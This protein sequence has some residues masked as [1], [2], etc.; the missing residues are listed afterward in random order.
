MHVVSLREPREI[1]QLM[2]QICVDKYGID[3]MLPKAI[4]R[5]VKL[6]N[7]SNITANILKQEMLSLGAD[8]AIARGSLTGKAKK[9]DCLLMGNISQFSR[10]SE[11]LKLQPFGLSGLS[12][13]LKNVL[14]DYQKEDYILN[15]GGIKFNLWK[16]TLVMA[17][18][19]LTPDSFSAD[20]L[21]GL[22]VSRIVRIIEEKKNQGVD[23]IDIGGESSRPGAKPVSVKEELRRV[24]PVV[25][26]VFKNIKIPISVDTSKPQVAKA[27]LENGACLINDITGLK[28]NK[29]AKIILEAKAGVIIMHMKGSP[30]TMQ[31]NPQYKCVTDEIIRYLGQRI[32]SAQ[33]VGI[34]KEKIIVDP[35]IGF[36]KTLEHNLEILRKLSEFRS[37]GVPIMV[38]VSRKSFIGKLTNSSAQERIPGS[39][40]AGVLAVI[41]GAHIVRVHDVRE[42]V[43][44]MRVIDAVVKA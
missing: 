19:N 21:F 11:K 39:I 33:S 15:L 14:S 24:I 16:R 41:N 28:D 27:A 31:K 32:E 4:T 2:R 37:L 38:G 36:G 12:R 20:G 9:T 17:I 23:I 8:A 7:L 10:L 30:R 26:A 1:K 42:T 29:M 25:Q 34:P 40:A 3:I 35:G 13:D 6:N 5:L 22:P 43:Q 44:A 18:V